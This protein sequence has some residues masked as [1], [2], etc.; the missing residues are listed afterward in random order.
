M[1]QAALYGALLLALHS[2]TDYPLR[3]LALETVLAAFIGRALAGTQPS[4][5]PRR[6]SKTGS[7]SEVRATTAYD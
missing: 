2:I 4:A 5:A 7:F 6:R 3:T 1:T